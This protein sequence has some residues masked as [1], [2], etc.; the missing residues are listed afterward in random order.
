MK[1]GKGVLKWSN[2]DSYEG[3]FKDNIFHGD[4]AL[5]TGESKYVG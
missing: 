4:G 1:A 2:G 3:D 5:I